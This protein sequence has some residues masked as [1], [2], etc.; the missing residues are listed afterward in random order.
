MYAGTMPTAKVDLHAIGEDDRV[1]TRL[2][3][4]GDAAIEHAIAA[5][6]FVSIRDE[7]GG[8][9]LAIVEWVNGAKIALKVDWDSWIPVAR[10]DDLT[11]IGDWKTGLSVYSEFGGVSSSTSVLPVSVVATA[12]IA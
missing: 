6:E 12:M 2:A 1:V 10:V 7:G 8:L 11:L 4:F 3:N 5:G 9:M